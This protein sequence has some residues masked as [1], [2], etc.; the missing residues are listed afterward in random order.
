[1]T[2]SYR[3]IS[4]RCDEAM[5]RSKEKCITPQYRRW[6]CTGECKTCIC[7]IYQTN[8]GKEHHV[9]LLGKSTG[10]RTYYER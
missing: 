8:D 2:I 4:R 7:C 6:R 5:K 10:D 9:N 3:I 1:M